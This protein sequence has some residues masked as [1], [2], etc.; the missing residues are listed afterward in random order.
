[1]KIKRNPIAAAIKTALYSSLLVSVAVTGL[2]FAQEDDDGSKEELD[3]VVVTGSR[4]K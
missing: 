4:I 2:A 1:M 3:K